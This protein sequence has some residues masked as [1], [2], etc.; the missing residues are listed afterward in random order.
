MILHDRPV[1]KRE[2][3]GSRSASSDHTVPIKKATAAARLPQVD[4]IHTT[5][6]GLQFLPIPCG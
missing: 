5:D 2:R 6:A 4:G 3:N 1:A